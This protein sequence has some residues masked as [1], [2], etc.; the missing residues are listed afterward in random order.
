MGEG[1]GVGGEAEWTVSGVGDRMEY[2]GIDDRLS[3][4]ISEDI[5]KCEVL[6]SEGYCTRND[7][8]YLVRKYEMY[9]PNFGKGLGSF[10]NSASDANQIE[11]LKLFHDKLKMI[12]TIG[13]LP[14]F[15]EDSNGG[16]TVTNIASASNQT[17]I[18]FDLKEM[19]PTKVFQLEKCLP[20]IN[21]RKY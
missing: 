21:T 1:W 13:Y 6:I 16:V 19:R 11:R 10:C 3:S 7:V 2:F 9:F 18:S 5:E 20:E 15:Q 8:V 12:N 14:A 4:C 17:Q